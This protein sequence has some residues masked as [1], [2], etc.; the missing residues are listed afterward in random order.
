MVGHHVE[1][2]MIAWAWGSEGQWDAILQDHALHCG[3]W[4]LRATGAV[5]DSFVAEVMTSIKHLGAEYDS[6][7]AEVM[8]SIKH[9][10]SHVLL[11]FEDFGNSNAFRV[12]DTYRNSHCCFNDDIQFED[13]GNNNAF[14]VL[15]TYRNSYCCFNDDIQGTATICL[16]ALLASLRTIGKEGSLLGQRILFLGAGE[17]GTGI[18]ELIA[19]YLHRRA[20]LTME[21]A[22]GHCFFID[23][24]GLVCKSRLAQLQHHKIP[25]AHD[26]EPCQ[27]LLTAIKTIKPTILIGRTRTPEF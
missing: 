9:L 23:S 6:F 16:A 19:Y 10:G 26:M 12:L 5:Y 27:D 13:F 21:E 2:N 11:Q 14:R 20:G 17:A 4:Q 1:G 7:V 15:D 18:G 25:F 22:R 24:K 3:R 8:T